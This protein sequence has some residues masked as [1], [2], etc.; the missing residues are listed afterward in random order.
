MAGE[1]FIAP[2]YR[3]FTVDLMSNSLLAEIPFVGVSYE[4]ALKGAGSFSGQIPVIDE[5]KQFD[6]YETTM[7]GRTALYVVRDNVCVWGGIIWSRSYSV[8]SQNLDVS[9]SEFTSYLQRRNIWKTWT[10]DFAGTGVA[11]SGVLTVTLDFSTYEFA[12]GASLRLFFYEVGDFGFNGYRTILASPAPTDTSFSVSIP[13]LPDGTYENMSVFIRTDT[14]DYVRELLSSMNIDFENLPFGNEEIEPALSR[15][16]RIV[17]FSRTGG[18]VRINTVDEHGAVVGQSVDIGDTDSR[19]NGTHEV[20]EVYSTTSLAVDIPGTNIGTTSVSARTLNVTSKQLTIY[21][22]A[23]TTSAP[24]GLVVGS[25]VT[26]SGVDDPTQTFNIFD[27]EFIVDSVPSATQFTFVTG[28]VDDIAPTS[29]GGTVVISP[30]LYNNTYGPYPANADIGLEYSTLEYSG[31]NV[32]NKTYRGY[33]LRSIG[34]ELDEYSDTVDGFE[35]R[36]DCYYDPGTASFGREFVLLPINFPDPPAPGE[37]APLSRYGAD[38]FIFTYPGNISEIKIDESAE[39]AATRFF[40]VGNIGDLGDDASQP[41]AAA[42]AQDLLQAGWPLLDQEEEVSDIADEETLYKYAKRYLDE[43]RPP[44]ADITVSVNGS[45][46]PVVGSYAPGDWCAIIVDDEFFKMRLASDLEVR[47][48]VIVRKILGYKVSVPDVVA[49]PEKVDLD[50][51]TE[52][53]VDKRGE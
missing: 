17:N 21:T 36:V 31:S 15:P 11:S 52:A 25:F 6:L 30:N 53:E 35:Y 51:I 44:I 12:A 28:G 10:H 49:F 16:H 47:D 19:I 32:A 7:P 43:H 39:E 4:R 33:E 48:D 13:G 8:E 22:A 26:I 14:Y 42:S 50:L 24:H 38:R 40:T 34:E 45:L 46:Q 5:T 2:K 41:Y 18:R 20:A 9:A 3:Y 23:I 1:D 27:G 29:S 37:V